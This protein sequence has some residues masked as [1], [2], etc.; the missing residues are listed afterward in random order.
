MNSHNLALLADR[1]VPALV[2]LFLWLATAALLF[3]LLTL[4]SSDFLDPLLALI[5]VVLTAAGVLATLWTLRDCWL[6]RAA[7]RDPGHTDLVLRAIADANVRGEA[8][9]LFVLAALFIVG[10]SVVLRFSDPTINRLLFICIALALV[11]NSVLD[12][13]ERRA[14]SLLLRATKPPG[15][16]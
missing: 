13:L 2:T 1:Y 16:L 6:E 12:R 7:T 14:T 11:S 4:R 3:G 10:L 5:W 8:V 15:A 9:R